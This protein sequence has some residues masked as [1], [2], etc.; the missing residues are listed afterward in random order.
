MKNKGDITVLADIL[1][2]ASIETTRI[3]T[4]RTL[5]EQMELLDKL[6]TW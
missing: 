5:D 3:Y 6:V 1:G 2:H 4:R